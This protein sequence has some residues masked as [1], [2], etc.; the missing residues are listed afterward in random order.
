MGDM[1][2]TLRMFTAFVDGEGYAGKV[3]EG[4]PPKLTLKTE[5]FEDGAMPAPVDISLA[6]IEKM[7]FELSLKEV[8]SAVYKNFGKADL[9]FTLRG[10]MSN[11]TDT[12]A[13]I[14]QMRGLLREIDPG[15]FKKGDTQG[16]C[17]FTARRL[18]LTIATEVVVEIDAL[19]HILKFGGVDYLAKDRQNLGL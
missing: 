17:S 10:S 15:T 9:P 4:T 16:K 13:V 18:K 19:N 2:K 6:S 5:E 1:P 8:T 3:I 11:G 12:V 7:V 14:Y